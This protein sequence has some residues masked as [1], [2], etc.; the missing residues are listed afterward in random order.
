MKKLNGKQICHIKITRQIISS[1]RDK[2]R[3]ILLNKTE[4]YN[5]NHKCNAVAYESVETNIITKL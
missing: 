3:E 4:T 5:N 2:N 1:V